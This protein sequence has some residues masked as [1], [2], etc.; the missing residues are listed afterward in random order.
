MGAATML[1]TM[2]ANPALLEEFSMLLSDQNTNQ[3][4]ARAVIIL[5][6][7]LHIVCLNQRQLPQKPHTTN[8]RAP[9]SNL[10]D[11]FLSLPPLPASALSCPAN[12][13]VA[14]A[15]KGAQKSKKQKTAAKEAPKEKMARANPK[16]AANQ[17]DSCR[18][19][20][21]TLPLGPPVIQ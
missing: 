1:A 2:M 19:A 12:R 14:T 20:D 15:P 8:N 10:S 16:V 6:L 7:M 11:S 4:K 9:P 5:R 3:N 18:L 21:L 13:D 17:S